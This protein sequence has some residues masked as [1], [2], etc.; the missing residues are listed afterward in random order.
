MKKMYFLLFT[1]LMTT[2]LFTG[3]VARASSTT[4]TNAYPHIQ[5]VFNPNIY[6]YQS[7]SDDPNDKTISQSTMKVTFTKPSKNGSR[8]SQWVGDLFY[9]LD[10][11]VENRQIV[12]IFHSSNT[13]NALMDYLWNYQVDGRNVG[14]DRLLNVPSVDEQYSVRAS[15]GYHVVG[16]DGQVVPAD[17]TMHLTRPHFNISRPVTV[18]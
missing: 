8:I 17:P 6:L 10:I 3:N 14:G 7:K 15:K 4:D 16:I 12:F 1:L 5:T 11:R 9:R 13:D 18:Y 2:V